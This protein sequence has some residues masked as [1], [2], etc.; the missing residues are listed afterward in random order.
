MLQF[1]L[2]PHHTGGGTVFRADAAHVAGLHY[3]WQDL[4]LLKELLTNLS[5][6]CSRRGCYLYLVQQ[7]PKTIQ[8]KTAHCPRRRHG[9]YFIFC[10]CL[11]HLWKDSQEQK[12]MRISNSTCRYLSKRNEY[13]KCPH[14]DLTGT[15]ISSFIHDQQ[16]LEISQMPVNWR[17]DKLWYIHKMK[18][19]SAIK[20]NELLDTEQH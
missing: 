8:N 19:H 1:P 20:R 17:K 13:R 9:R 3:S 11:K 12:L 16:K 4:N 10:G 15:V 5:N 14:K 6:F 18:C 2:P 7:K